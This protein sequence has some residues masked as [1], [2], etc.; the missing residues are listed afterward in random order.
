MKKVLLALLLI[1]V[2]TMVGCSA[3]AKPSETKSIYEELESDALVPE[4]ERCKEYDVDTLR[5]SEINSYGFYISNHPASKIKDKNIVKLCNI[6]KYEFKNII[7]YVMIENVVN[8][9]TKKGEDMAFIS[10]SDETGASDFTVF[11]NKYYLLSNIKK[12]D[13]IKVWGSVTKRYAKTSVIV[14]NINKE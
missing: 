6:K 2:S 14:S 10:A 8:I 9:K 12:N 1:V 13:V 3:T 7:C 4:M 11:P 5:G